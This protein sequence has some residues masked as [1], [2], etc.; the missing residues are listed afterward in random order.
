MPKRISLYCGLCFCLLFFTAGLFWDGSSWSSFAGTD[1]VIRS[2]AV[3]PQGS[4]HTSNTSQAT[5]SALDSALGCALPGFTA[6]RRFGPVDGFLDSLVKGDFNNDGIPDLADVEYLASVSVWL[7][8]SDGTLQD[9]VGYSAG[10]NP[11]GIA[12]GDFNHDGN[13]DLAVSNLLDTTTQSVSVLMG[14]GD[15]SFAEPVA[16]ASYSGPVAVADFNHD[17]KLDIATACSLLL[18]N[19]NGTFQAPGH[20]FAP[21]GCVSGGVGN[22]AIADFNLDGNPDLVGLSDGS[23]TGVASIALGNGNGTFNGPLEFAVG[24][25]P[26][27][28]AVADLNGDGKPDLAVANQGC[29]DCAGAETYGDVSVL[30]GNGNGT[31]QGAVSTTPGGDPAS[32]AIGDFNQDGKPDLAIVKAG[33]YFCVPQ[34]GSVVLMIGKGDGTFKPE[35][36]YEAVGNGPG[37]VSADFNLDGAPDLAFGHAGHP[38]SVSLLL[39]NGD[40]TLQAPGNYPVGS[41]P[42]GVAMGD[43]NGDGHPDLAAANYDD[44]NVSVLLANADGTFQAASPFAAGLGPKAVATGDFDENGKLDLATAAFDSNKASVILGNGGGTFQSPQGYSVGLAQGPSSISVRDLNG[45]AHQ[46]LIVG[47]VAGIAVFLGKGDGTFQTVLTA[48]LTSVATSVAV[49]DLNGDGWL[50]L[51]ATGPESDSVV[52]LLGKG[53]G[54]FAS[55]SNLPAG[56][57]L[58]FVT[59]ADFNLDGAPDLAIANRLSDEVSVLLGNGDGTFQDSTS[60]AAGGGPS[61]LTAGDFN[62]D[63]I[64]DLAV[65]DRYEWTVSVLLGNG[66]GSFQEPA[67]FDVGVTPIFLAAGDLNGDHRPDLV[68]ANVSSDDVSVLRNTCD[69]AGVGVSADI[70]IDQIDSPDPVDAGGTLTYTLLVGNAGPD[71]ASSLTVTDTL[72]AGAGFLCASGTGACGAAKGWICNA[73]AGVVTCTRTSLGVGAAPFITLKVTAPPSGPVNNA[74]A[75]TAADYDPVQ[76]NNQST[77]HTTIAAP[78]PGVLKFSSATYD[79]SET[80]PSATITVTRTAGSAGLVTVHYAT[81]GGTATAGADYTATSGTL[82][83]AGGETSKTFAVPILNDGSAEPSETINLALSSP[84]GG[85]S[86]GTPSSAVLTIL[87]N[88]PPVPTGTVQF[89]AASYTV[90]ESSLA[91]ITVTRTVSTSGTVSVN[92]ATSNGTATAGADY[93][94]ASGVVTLGPGVTSKTFT[95][96]IL[97]D[98]LDEA[99]ET[100]ILTLSSPTGGGVLGL[101]NAV[102]TITDDDV[103]GAMKFSAATYSVS[104]ATASA[105]ITVTRS[106]G[107]ACGVSVGYATG[108]GTATA[109]VDYTKLAGTLSFASGQTS[110]TFTLPIFPDT[111]D[112]AN[113]TVTLLLTNPAGG[114]TLGTPVSSILT[115]T[116]NDTGGVLHFSAA[117]YSSGEAGGGM[118]VTVT[119][120]GG[121]ASGVVVG[122]W[123]RNGTA[124]AGQDYTETLGTLTFGAGETSKTFHVPILNDGLGE[125]NETVNL[126][127]S[128][129]TGGGTLG[130][131]AAAVLTLIDDE[132]VLQFKTPTFSVT[133]GAVNATITVVRSGPTTAAVGAAYS[134]GG[135]TATAGSDYTAVSGVVTLGPGVTSKTF[136][137]PILADCSD[138]D[139]ETI[140]LSL[141][142]PTGGALLGPLGTAVLTINDNDAG[143]AMRFSAATYSVSEASASFNVTVTRSGGTACGASIDYATHDGTASQS[144][145]Y[146]AAA[147]GT[148]TF[149]SGQTSRTF[150]VPVL[151]DTLDEPNETV[152]LALSNPTGGATLGNP[153]SSVLSITDNDI[154]GVLHFSASTYSAGEGSGSAIIKVTRASGLA[155]GV[156]VDYTLSNGT[157]AGG[158]DYLLAA[159]TVSFGAGETSKT[160]E[161]Q[162]TNDQLAE[163]NETLNLALSAPTGLATLGAPSTAVLTIV[164]DE[165]ALQFKTPTFTIAEGA[166]N[167]TLT[168][169]RS[170]PTTSSVG[171]A[172]TVS[173]GTATAGSDYTTVAGTVT[174]GPGVTSKTFTVPILADCL[175]EADEKVN[176]ALSSPTGGAQ[177]GPLSSAVLTITDNDAGGAMRFSAATYSVNEGSASVTITVTRSGGT[178][179]GVSV[180]YATANGTAIVGADYTSASGTLSFGSGQTSKTFTVPILPDTLDEPNETVAL[181]LSNPTGG[182]TLGTPVTSVLTVVDN[183]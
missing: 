56:S 65:S 162:I 124:S 23:S 147:A 137:V 51:A 4:L 108:T 135:G 168:V 99:N 140:N 22:I 177:L 15:G 30:L 42:E 83:F 88:D 91:T 66:N 55:P 133:E 21:Q 32:V 74:A 159:G 117:T 120:S 115:I 101:H 82:S 85:A 158:S 31:F 107:T 3:T 151:P 92:Y 57:D 76:A 45:D 171:A 17:T 145:D 112:E 118:N 14:N 18:G 72:P 122:Y 67:R 170:G 26:R 174:L 119:R 98:C 73:A 116:D 11:Y 75:V 126:A 62:R 95:V 19:G 81:S 49:A 125:G 78:L 44:G 109:D 35:I 5:T 36:N 71:S 68:V 1:G 157:A 150:T 39:G 114:A 6:A 43:F 180:A 25:K 167:A 63:G 59:A 161:V 86:V 94:S 129:P 106:G 24:V 128:T 46:D 33:C 27:S 10:T 179:C 50:D 52:I 132:V 113:E 9:P 160:F 141:S 153:A 48:A 152:L 172:Y 178:G 139:N 121:L 175:D 103:G 131:P 12:A 8:N 102:L 176:L 104:E 54:T 41:S 146:T 138:E 80:G 182:A 130:T 183:D 123:T 127:L 2:L 89:S 136:T 93:S 164:D 64:L 154:G 40:G 28:V 87:D 34:L 37:L 29:N 155:S 7:G 181:A 149:A 70:A 77:G 58:E 105:T 165:V 47:N 173:D 143:G 100:V 38:F 60:F 169:V 61:S 111:L 163:G 110:K 96:P 90:A 16:Y 142:A 156:T 20:I 148:L 144:I 79:V 166:V 97:V 84:T 13:L 134:V 69:A 53:D